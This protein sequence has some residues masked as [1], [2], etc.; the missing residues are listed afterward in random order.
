M[1]VSRLT[2][3]QRDVLWAFFARER[4]FFL[5]GGGALVGFYLFH[6]ETTDLDL[7]APEAILDEG[8][9]ALEAVAGELGATVEPLGSGP[10]IRRCS[11]R[12][13]DQSVKVDLVWEPV[14]QW[15][16]EKR[17]IDGILVDPPQ[18]ILANKLGALLGRLEVR[19]LVDVLALE[20]EG[21]RVEDAIAA[22]MEKEGGLT[23]AQ[24]A[25]LLASW[26][27]APDSPIPSG[28]SFDELDGFR[29]DLIRRL[30]RLAFP[31]GT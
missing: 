6:R 1:P 10:S 22:A 26:P 12:R 24:L 3:L 20:R 16:P 29:R 11:L 14:P 19:D 8:L 25:D 23:P 15:F 9:E 13:G 30:R 31:E 28:F 27:L 2:P 5:S 21:F 4:R 18:E 17:S 7:F